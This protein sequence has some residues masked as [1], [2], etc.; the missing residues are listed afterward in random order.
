MSDSKAKVLSLIANK[1]DDPLVSKLSL[2][3]NELKIVYFIAALDSF[4][5][6]SLL[7]PF[8]SDYVL[9]DN[10]KDFDRLVGFGVVCPNE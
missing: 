1:N 6:D 7:R 5:S 10:K 4:R 9:A 3:E 2:I 8:P